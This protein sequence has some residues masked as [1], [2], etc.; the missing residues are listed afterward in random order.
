VVTGGLLITPTREAARREIGPIEIQPRKRRSLTAKS[1][2]TSLV[3]VI[4]KETIEERW[5]RLLKT[6]TDAS[7]P[8]QEHR[9]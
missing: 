3:E 7:V 5:N 2:K 9:S 8:D 6:K 1:A 4:E